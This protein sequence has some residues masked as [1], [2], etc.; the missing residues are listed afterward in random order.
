MTRFRAALGELFQAARLTALVTLL[1]LGASSLLPLAAGWI[2][3]VVVSG[4]MTPAVR[5][6]DLVFYQRARSADVR[7]GR[8]LLADQPG[9]EGEL[10]SHRVVSVDPD[11]TITTKGDAN[12]TADSDPVAPGAVR[13]QARLIVPYVGLLTLINRPE[14]R[15]RIAVFVIVVLLAASYRPAGRR[16]APVVGPAGRTRRR[17]RA[18]H[19]TRSHPVAIAVNLSPSSPT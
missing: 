15:K 4:S 10:L 3:A 18:R 11:G 8:I 6:G 16:P 2:P 12:A 14:Q 9:H 19:R 1:S 17:H 13:G 7:P 5:P